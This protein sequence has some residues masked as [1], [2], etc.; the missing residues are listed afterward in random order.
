MKKVYFMFFFVVFLS[1]KKTDHNNKGI[2]YV[3]DFRK[4]GMTDYETFKAAYDSIPNHSKIIFAAK[5]YIFN[6]T[7]IIYKT[8]DFYGPATLK[9]ED[10]ITY[11]LKV[12][13]DKTSNIL[14]LN[15]TEGIITGDRFFVTLGQ[16]HSDNTLIDF[17]TEVSGDTLFLNNALGETEDSVGT[18]PIGSKFFK[19]INIFWVVSDN[20]PPY[21]GCSFNNLIFDGNR[22]NNKGT[23]SWLLNAAVIAVTKNTTLYRYCT[24]TNSPGESIVGHNADIR[25]C[26]FYNLNGSGFHTSANKEKW[27]ESDI[28]SYLSD[29]TFENTNQIPNLIGGHSEGAITHSNSGGYYTATRNT[30]INVGESVLAGLYPS[31]SIF[32]WGTSNINFTGNTINGAGKIVRFIAERPGIIHDVKIEKNNISNMPYFDWTQELTYWPGIILKDKN[33]E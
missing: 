26:T 24:F 14:I 8:L 1:C 12:T 29:N 6:H 9:R 31:V 11:T 17:V 28:H 22:D 20:L 4:P 7:P 19:N 27:S 23:Y 10:Q 32:D 18:F 2:F 33:G 16:T 3:E 15:S 30:F 13:A 25:N 21:Q 5:T